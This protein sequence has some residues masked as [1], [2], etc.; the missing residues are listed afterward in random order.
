[1]I[2]D[3][4]VVSNGWDHVVLEVNDEYV[5]RFPRDEGVAAFRYGV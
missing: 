1:M 3:V 5:F 2:R 4:N